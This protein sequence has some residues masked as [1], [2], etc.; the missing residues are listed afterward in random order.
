MTRQLTLPEPSPRDPRF[1]GY[2]RIAAIYVDDVCE[3]FMALEDKAPACVRVHLRKATAA[4]LHPFSLRYFISLPAAQE[5]ITRAAALH[6]SQ[7][8]LLK[9]V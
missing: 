8:D 3:G 6:R 4:W 9:E 1:P 2:R 7:S 5:A